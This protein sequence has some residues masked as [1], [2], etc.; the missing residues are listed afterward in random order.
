MT[1]QPG[2]VDVRAGAA[3]H[4]LDGGGAIVP[5]SGETMQV[6]DGNVRDGAV[7]ISP[8]DACLDVG[9][10]RIRCFARADVIL[11]LREVLRQRRQCCRVR[12]RC[13]PRSE[14]VSNNEDGDD[15]QYDLCSLLHDWFVLSSPLMMT[16]P[17][18][19]TPALS[20]R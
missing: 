10:E 13:R 19:I 4:F 8:D 7:G 9:L 14:Q 5:G 11:E 12:R 15:R 17:T 16:D 6:N 1:V 20:A 3:R 18:R 2:K